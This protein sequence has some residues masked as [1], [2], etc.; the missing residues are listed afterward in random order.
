MIENLPCLHPLEGRV[1]ETIKTAANISVRMPYETNVIC[2]HDNDERKGTFG[3]WIL[4][5]LKAK[6]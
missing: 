5:L 2:K 1:D 3:A 6:S 4:G